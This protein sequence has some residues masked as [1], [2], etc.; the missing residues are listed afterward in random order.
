MKKTKVNAILA[1][2]L[3]LLVLIGICLS[4]FALTDI[5]HGKEPNLET[6]WWTV[7]ITFVLALK[8]F[9]NYDEI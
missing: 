8:V 6:E 9:R 4:H 5:Y 3:S 7:R 2:V 1:L